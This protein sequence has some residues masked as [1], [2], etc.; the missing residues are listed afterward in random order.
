MFGRTLARIPRT[1][2]QKIFGVKVD[3]V[4]AVSHNHFLSFN[5]A[6]FIHCFKSSEKDTA[7]LCWRAST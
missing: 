7:S 3:I 5:Q 2:D 4:T 1:K 6:K